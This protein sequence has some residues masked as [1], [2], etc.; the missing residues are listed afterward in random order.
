MLPN[1][2]NTLLQVV[3]GWIFK[4]AVLTFYYIFIRSVHMYITYYVTKY[5]S[6][7]KL[8]YAC[9]FTLDR[10]KIVYDM[11]NKQQ[12]KVQNLNS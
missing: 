12:T 4:N 10:K 2:Q 7:C 8:I 1:Y 3:Q 11:Q 9:L 6:D 5:Y